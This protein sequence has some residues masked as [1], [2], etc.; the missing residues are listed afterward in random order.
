MLPHEQQVMY[1]LPACMFCRLINEI[2]GKPNCVRTHASSTLCTYLHASKMVNAGGVTG[3]DS[4]F[5]T[6]PE[7]QILVDFVL[8]NKVM[9]LWCCPH[10]TGNSTMAWQL[11]HSTRLENHGISAVYIDL[12]ETDIEDIYTVSTSS[13]ACTKRVAFCGKL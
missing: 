11:R 3:T 4:V 6:S 13:I 8:S 2:E 10:G 7:I 12:Q 5:V 1:T 9:E